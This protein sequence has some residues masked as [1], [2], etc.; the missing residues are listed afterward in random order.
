MICLNKGEDTTVVVTFY[1]LTTIAPVYYLIEVTSSN[2]DVTY[3]APVDVSISVERYNKFVINS[4][5]PA[6]EY[7]YTAYQCAAPSPTI[8]DAQGVVEH[9]ILV[10]TDDGIIDTVYE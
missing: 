9:G 3:I 5:L 6:G 2:D 4:D 10:V 8:D 1:E 7:Y